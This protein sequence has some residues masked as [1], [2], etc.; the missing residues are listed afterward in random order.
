MNSKISKD[1]EEYIQSQQTTLQYIPPDIHCTNSA[2]R[3]IQTWKNHFIAR[4]AS[5]LPKSFPIANWCHLTN[6]CDYTVNMLLPCH[7]NPSL[8][9]FEAMEG[10]FY[11]NAA[12]MVPPGTKVLIHLK[13][14]CCKS[15]SFHVSNGWYI[16]PSLKYYHCICP[17]MEGMGGEQLTDTFCFKHYAMPVPTVT[18][19]DRII[20]AT[21][22]LTVAITS[23]QEDPLEELQAIQTLKQLLLGKTPPFPVP[24][25]PPAPPL[26]PTPIAPIAPIVL[27]ELDDEPIHMWDPRQVPQCAPTL[28]L[29]SISPTNNDYS[30]PKHITNN[31]AIKNNAIPINIPS[32]SGN[33]SRTRAQNRRTR[34]QHQAARVHLVN[35]AITKALV[36]MLD[37]K[38]ARTYPSHGYIAAA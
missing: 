19:T 3:A 9:P 12:P 38:S 37:T 34:T 6:Q 21:R 4:I 26:Q 10:S 5:L 13:P 24:V 35:T 31:H 33:H 14:A 16:G 25:D 30:A 11:F 1:V 29:N 36:P 15:W 27:C 22:Q 17:I 8:L 2:E 28:Q 7:H 23:I 18:P 20:A 32:P